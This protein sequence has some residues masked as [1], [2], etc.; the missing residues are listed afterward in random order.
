M[1]SSF[2]PPRE[3]FN[4]K[5]YWILSVLTINCLPSAFGLI[6]AVFKLHTNEFRDVFFK[7]P[8]FKIWT[9]SPN[10]MSLGLC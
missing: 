4:E 6:I 3:F 2:I 8:V 1:T 5:A 9:T 7:G 10:T